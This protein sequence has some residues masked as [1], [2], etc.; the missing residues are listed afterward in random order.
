MKD[1]G[2]SNLRKSTVKGKVRVDIPSGF[3]DDDLESFGKVMKVADRFRV[4]TSSEGA[5]DLV[6]LAIRKGVKATLSP[7]TLEDVFVDIIGESEEA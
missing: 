5:E 7:I 2:C 3:S 6:G 4:L 1:E